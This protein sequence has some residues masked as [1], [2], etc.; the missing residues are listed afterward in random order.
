MG[1]YSGQQEVSLFVISYSLFGRSV[2]MICLEGLNNFYDF[3][4]FYDFYEMWDMRY[5]VTGGLE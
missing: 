5:W 4:A 1:K 3:Y 2:A